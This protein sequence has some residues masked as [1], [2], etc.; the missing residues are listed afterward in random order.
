MKRFDDT[1]NY[2]ALETAAKS[3]FGPEGLQRLVDAYHLTNNAMVEAFSAGRSEGGAEAYEAGKAE[4]EV[5][6][7]AKITELRRVEFARG[8]E[9]GKI[10][11]QI[12]QGVS[13]PDPLDWANQNPTYARVLAQHAQT[14]AFPPIMGGAAAAVQADYELQRDSGDEVP[15]DH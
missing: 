10:A 15:G 8:V 11:V 4:A 6:D 9:A 3:I 14:K 2:R 5:A 12:D 1:L 13:A 7:A